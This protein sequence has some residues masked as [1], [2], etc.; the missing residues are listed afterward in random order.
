MFKLEQPK[1]DNTDRTVFDLPYGVIDKSMILTNVGLYNANCSTDTGVYYPALGGV[2]GLFR[3]VTLY[4]GAQILSQYRHPAM[5]GLIGLKTLNSSAEDLDR[6]ELLNGVAIDTTSGDAL[7]YTPLNKDY[8]SEYYDVTANNN[9]GRNRFHNQLQMANANSNGAIGG[10]VELN[11]ILD[12]LA[13]PGVLNW[14]PNLSLEIVWETRALYAYREDPGRKSAIAGAFAH[15]Q[16]RIAMMVEAEN[17]IPVGDMGKKVQEAFLEKVVDRVI[18][19]ANATGG[20]QS[21]SMRINGFNGKYVNDLTLIFNPDGQD[22]WVLRNDRS[23]CPEQEQIQLVVNGE[24]YL[25]FSNIV[26]EAEKMRRAMM[27]HGNLNVPLAGALEGLANG[28]NKYLSVDAANA[29]NSTSH[30]IGNANYHAYLIGKVVERLELQHSRANSGT[31]ARNAEYT[32]YVIG[33]CPKVLSYKVGD[34]QVNI[35]A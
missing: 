32:L 12:I 4:S 19:A 2:L 3:E 14:M 33:T 34:K 13:A 16:P 24:N 28:A 5:G 30:I 18:I 25:P 6:Y 20:T 15:L 11:R 10:V 29:A 23:V 22:N 27:V 35:S 1:I 9:V 8:N 26:N 31:A 7:D 21:Q 17:E